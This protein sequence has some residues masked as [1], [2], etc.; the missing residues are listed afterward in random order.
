MEL[1][2]LIPCYNEEDSIKECVLTSL[3]V[4]KKNKIKGEVLVI[5]NNCTDSSASLARSA[6][7]RVV[8]EKVAGYGAAI[9]RG[10]KEAKGKYIIMADAD[11][12]YDFN[13]AVE[14]LEFLN[15]GYDMVIGNRFT[16]K[17]DKHA[18]SFSHKYI[19]NPFLSFIGRKLFNIKVGDFHCGL[20]GY[21]KEKMLS[22][23]LESTGM[24]LAS[25]M[26]I[27]ATEAKLN[28]KEI[29]IDFK[30]D[31]RINTTSKLHTFKD[32]YRH[33]KL[34]IDYYKEK[35]KNERKN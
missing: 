10:N 11:M 12:S 8:E 13:Y 16:G 28:I 19:G 34:M 1:T 9:N 18:M 31:H 23:N 29:P 2:I 22:L 35:R 3:E 26:V 27:K 20:R 24:E 25:E 5:D 15:N 32:A 33:L 6:G 17:M 7:A 30:K 21:S 14:F 4:L